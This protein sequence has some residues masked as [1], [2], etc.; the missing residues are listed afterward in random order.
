[1]RKAIQYPN[2]PINHIINE[3]KTSNDYRPLFTQMSQKKDMLRV[4][5]QVQNQT[6]ISKVICVCQSFFQS[7]GLLHRTFLP[8][9]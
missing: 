2:K 6:K 8:K 7:P 4:F 9:P 3:Q 5:F 1:M